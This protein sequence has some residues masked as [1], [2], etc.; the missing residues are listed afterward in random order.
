MF[1]PEE[2]NVHRGTTWSATAT[3]VGNYDTAV[4]P[5]GHFDHISFSAVATPPPLFV[6]CNV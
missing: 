6:A 2:A 4:L 1:T 5:L 3:P